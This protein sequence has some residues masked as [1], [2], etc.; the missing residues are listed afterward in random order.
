MNTLEA[1]TKARALISDR[2]HW[3]QNERRVKVR[4]GFA[5]CAYGALDEATGKMQ[6]CEDPLPNLLLAALPSDFEAF[7]YKDYAG[8][9]ADFNNSKSH[10]EVLAVFDR[11]IARQLEIEAMAIVPAETERV[12]A[13]VQP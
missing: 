1:L 8:P 10:A 2:R 6:R 13:L 12:P 7:F 5:Y 9:V 3:V 11:A 4:G